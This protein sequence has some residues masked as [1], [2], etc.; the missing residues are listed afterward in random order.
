MLFGCCDPKLHLNST[1]NP[2]SATKISGCADGIMEIELKWTQPNK[3]TWWHLLLER[4]LIRGYAVQIKATAEW[5]VVFKL[6]RYLPN[7]LSQ[8]LL[9][10][11]AELQCCRLGLGLVKD[12]KW[13]KIREVSDVHEWRRYTVFHFQFLT[14]KPTLSGVR[15]RVNMFVNVNI[16]RSMN[17]RN[18]AQ[19]WKGP[20][21]I[22]G[23]FFLDFNF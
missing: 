15:T 13:L 23:F 17:G 21:T 11:F 3:L 18:M 9:H 6:M 1:F 20:F 16:Q 2:K 12:Q 8:T 4:A 14:D 19:I 7:P 22:E 10:S 5:A